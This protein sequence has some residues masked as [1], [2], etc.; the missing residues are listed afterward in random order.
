MMAVRVFRAWGTAGSLK[1]PTP[2]LTASTPVMAVHPLANARIRIQRLAAM[3]GAGWG[4]GG[5][6]GTGLP[7]ARIDLISPMARTASSDAMNAWVGTMNAT[8][9]SRTPR[10]L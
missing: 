3:A 2:L 6:I 9:D 1:A 10:R 7:P 8:P 4:A 5:S